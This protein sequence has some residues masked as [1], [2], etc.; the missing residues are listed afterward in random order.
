MRKLIGVIIVTSFVIG[1]AFLL[2]QNNTTRQLPKSLSESNQVAPSSS[3]SEII[4]K[5]K[6]GG[7]SLSDPKGVFS[8]LYPNDYKTD[9]QNNGQY[10]RIYKTG[11]TQRGQTEMYDGVIITFESITLNSQKLESF[12]DEHIKSST[13]D[14]TTTVSQPKRA[15]VVNGYPGFSYTLHGLGESTYIV[16][17]KD[18]QSDYA[19]SISYAVMDPEKVG[20]QQEVDA[21][22][23]T[24]Q[25]LK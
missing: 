3:S 12:V 24:I 6:A 8:I 23:S 16:L 2:I 19:V 25:L 18:T 14:G 22:F 10:I 1:G 15:T 5:L 11:S 4:D 21:T 7:S 9:T 13:V 17:Q 20:Y